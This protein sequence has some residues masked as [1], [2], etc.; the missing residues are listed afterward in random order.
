MGLVIYTGKV[1]SKTKPGSTKITVNNSKDLSK[2][3]SLGEVF[4]VYVMV[5]VKDNHGKH[6]ENIW[7][8]VFNLT[9]GY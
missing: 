6:L 5:T 8:A 2:Q 7:F 3:H 1:F 9:V 4:K